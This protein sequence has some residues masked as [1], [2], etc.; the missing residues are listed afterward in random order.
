[1]EAVNYSRNILNFS[2]PFRK[3]NTSLISVRRLGSS[4]LSPRSAK[5]PKILSKRLSGCRG[6]FPRAAGTLWLV[7]SS[8]APTLSSSDVTTLL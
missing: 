1:M 7:C 3:G 6:T 5:R 8:E 2:L 4:S